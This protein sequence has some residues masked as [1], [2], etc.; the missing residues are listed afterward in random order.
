[1]AEYQDVVGEGRPTQGRMVHPL[2]KV[3][4]WVRVGGYPLM[5]LAVLSSMDDP[6]SVALPT[7]AIALAWPHIAHL[8]GRRFRHPRVPFRL[9]VFDGFIHGTFVACT[10]LQWTVTASDVLAVTAWFLMLGGVRLLIQGSVALA[11]GTG[12]TIPF[13]Q[14]GFWAA[15]S[16]AAV[17]TCITWLA[18]SFLLTSLLVNNTTR[19]FV[20][21]RRH[22]RVMNEIARFANATLDFDQVLETAMKVLQSSFSFHHMVVYL[23]DESRETL[24]ARTLL[25]PGPDRRDA[26]QDLKS[27][28][29]PVAETQS[30]FSYAFRNQTPF[31]LGEIPAEVVAAM[32]PHDRALFDR[33]PV[34]SLLILP[35]EV[36]DE[37]IGVIYFGNTQE[38]LELGRSEIKAIRHYMP[39]LAMALRNARLYEQ[40]QT[41]RREAQAQSAELEH[42]NEEIIRTQDQ[43]IVQEKMASLGQVTAGIAHEIKNPLNFVNNF[44][45]GSAELADELIGALE[46]QNGSLKPADIDDMMGTLRELKQN[47]V[48]ISDNGKRA[49]SIVRSMM[50]HA[51][52]T[53]GDR[54]VVDLN[55]LVRENLHLAYH[56]YRAGHPSFNVD[57]R[58]D[59]EG[60]LPV[61][62]VPQDLSRVLLNLLTNACHAV[63]EKQKQPGDAYSPAITVSTQ[64]SAE[65][66]V[67]RVRDNGPGIAGEVLDKIFDPFF[68]TKATGEGNTGLGLSIAYEI[69]T[70]EHRGTIEVDSEPGEFT[71]FVIQLPDSA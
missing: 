48:D 14:I 32:S 22:L 61:E 50:D 34:E 23:V 6:S 40:V 15:P 5:A 1:M 53:K 12:L 25:A 55:P 16:P 62:V 57:L 8:I 24:E 4:Y 18:F 28:S 17:I 43:L 69:V 41:A 31:F 65:A 38:K 10:G 68:T 7:I 3:S 35:L 2:V 36:E 26:A 13:F 11:V 46:K 51:R 27:L 9:L 45:E 42:K 58:E 20:S 29:I 60:P 47:A 59:L 19:R 63:H 56:G 39:L 21:T 49:D 66:V 52:G 30:A 37:T 64:A 70:Q 44:A 33:Y 71:E 54:R 67:I